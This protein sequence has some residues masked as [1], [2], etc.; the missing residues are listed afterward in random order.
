MF[1]VFVEHADVGD[2]HLEICCVNGTWEWS[3][4]HMRTGSKAT[5]QG[6]SLREAKARAEG[7]AAVKPKWRRVGRPG[8][9]SQ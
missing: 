5:G 4:F 3:V 6:K 7:V 1:K 9:G 8:A 2:F